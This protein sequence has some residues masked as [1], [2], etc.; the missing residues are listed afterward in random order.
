MVLGTITIKM[1]KCNVA[2]KVNDKICPCRLGLGHLGDHEFKKTNSKNDL[3]NEECIIGF[4][5]CS[6]ILALFYFA[7]TGKWFD[8]SIWWNPVAWG[9][10]VLTMFGT[11]GWLVCVGSLIWNFYWSKKPNEIWIKDKT[12]HFG[13]KKT[14]EKTKGDER[15][16]QELNND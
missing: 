5:I 8:S 14:L 16:I 4:I 15:I 6:G 9:L 1:T 13:W 12:S 2:L 7:V 10:I 3:S 11:I